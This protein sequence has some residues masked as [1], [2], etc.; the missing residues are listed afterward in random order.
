MNTYFGGNGFNIIDRG[1]GF[2]LDASI[3]ATRTNIEDNEVTFENAWGVCDSDIYNKVLKEADKAH[4]DGQP[5][6]DFVMTTSNHKPYTYPEGKIDVPSGTGREGAVKYTDY[7]IGE[8]LKM[9]KQKPWYDN[10]VFVIMS[11]HCASSAGRWELD[12]HNYHIPAMIINLP[13]QQPLKVNNLASQIDVFPT[14]FAQLNWDY[15]SNFFGRNILKMQSR[16][17]RC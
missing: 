1:R 12:V 13:N 8:F 15:E 6:F 11:D 16:V 9:A 3:T 17:C 5:F 10:T 4:R 2:L 14:L 7:A